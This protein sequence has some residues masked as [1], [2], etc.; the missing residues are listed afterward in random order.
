MA[1]LRNAETPLQLARKWPTARKSGISRVNSASDSPA[2]AFLMSGD[3]AQRDRA[4][5]PDHVEDALYPVL[6]L[7]DLRRSSEEV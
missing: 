6:A 1:F 5:P 3:V 4:V 7:L 2:S